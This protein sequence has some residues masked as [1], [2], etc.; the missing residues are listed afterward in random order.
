[1]DSERSLDGWLSKL[2]TTSRGALWQRRWF[3]LRGD[4]LRYHNS[5]ADAGSGLSGAKWSLEL[6]AQGSTASVYRD[7]GT[8][9]QDPLS[10]L[11]PPC[12]M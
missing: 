5:P 7:I 10:E 11:P 1:M 3:V 2:S 4:V 6:S 12:V 9:V 8:G